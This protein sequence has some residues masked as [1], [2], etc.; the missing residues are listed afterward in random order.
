MHTENAKL[1]LAF[2]PEVLQGQQLCDLLKQLLVK[3]CKDLQVL[4]QDFNS[5]RPIMPGSKESKEI[6]INKDTP[7]QH[8]KHHIILSSLNLLI[9][10]LKILLL[11]DLKEYLHRVTVVIDL[12]EATEVPLHLVPISTVHFILK[13]L[14]VEVEP[15]LLLEPK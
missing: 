3:G 9:K 1:R 8:H 12:G 6:F 15:G 13:V 7:I 2:L 5:F 11:A 4:D 14:H 10:S